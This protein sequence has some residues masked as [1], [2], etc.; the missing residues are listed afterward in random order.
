MFAAELNQAVSI[1]NPG[2]TLLIANDTYRY[3]ELRLRVSGKSDVPIVI[4]TEDP[5]KVIIRGK[6][7]L[8]IAGTYIEVH[9]LFFKDGYSSEEPVIDFRTEGDL[10][11]YCHATNCAISY[12]N[13]PSRQIRSYWIALHG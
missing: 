4:M 9:G 3:I 12:F 10:A 2:G 8:K 7:N 1:V 5:G 13:Q 6:Y 11:N